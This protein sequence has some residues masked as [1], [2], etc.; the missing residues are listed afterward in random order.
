MPLINDI[1]G[2]VTIRYDQLK[3]GDAA[4]IEKC[5]DPYSADMLKRCAQWCINYIKQHGTVRN[6]K[7][8]ITDKQAQEMKGEYYRAD[9]VTGNTNIF[10]K[11]SEKRI[12]LFCGDTR[13]LLRFFANESRIVKRDG[14]KAVLKAKQEEKREA[15]R[16]K[17]SRKTYRNR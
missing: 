6:G 12:Y 1:P 4:W 13:R 10:I 7:T 2:I 11:E 15:R 16:R 3:K 14:T 5:T 17:Q 8:G 9:F